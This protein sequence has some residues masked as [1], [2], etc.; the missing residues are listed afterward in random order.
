MPLVPASDRSIIHQPPIVSGHAAAT[1]PTRSTPSGARSSLHF[2]VPARPDQTCAAGRLR[3]SASRSMP[4]CN[5]GDTSACWSW[6]IGKSNNVGSF[7]ISPSMHLLFPKTISWSDTERMANRSVVSAELD[8][9]VFQPALG[10][11]LCRTVEIVG[12]AVGG[13]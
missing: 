11:E 5:K 1:S 10:Q 6:R 12:R 8:R 13:P 3:S 9:G 7:S 4:S 2:P